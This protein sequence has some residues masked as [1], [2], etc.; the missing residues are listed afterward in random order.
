M[1]AISPI[2]TLVT[3]KR[4]GCRT[5]FILEGKLTLAVIKIVT[6]NQEETTSH[7]SSAEASK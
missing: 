2:Q 5:N 4:Q 6:I 7:C 3:I 1:F